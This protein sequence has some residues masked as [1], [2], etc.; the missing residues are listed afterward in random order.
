MPHV[1]VKLWPGK[2]EEQKIRLKV[3]QLK[4][5]SRRKSK[6][7]ARGLPRK[8]RQSGSLAPYESIR[9]LRHPIRHMFKV[10]A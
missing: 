5:F 2:S 9:C 4:E 3:A 7:L 10:H 6:E 8:D 1:V